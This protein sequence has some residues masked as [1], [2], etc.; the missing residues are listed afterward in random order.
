MNGSTSM[1]S[2]CLDSDLILRSATE[3]PKAI[4]D[5]VKQHCVFSQQYSI[6]TS[7]STLNASFFYLT[8]NI[9]IY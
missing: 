5:V 6:S 4:C 7:G 1:S 3:N 9:E 8:L 2:M